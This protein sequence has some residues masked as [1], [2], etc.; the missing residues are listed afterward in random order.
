[1]KRS[2]DIQ[3][4][5]KSA[6]RVS[7][8]GAKLFH[9]ENGLPINRIAFTLARK[10]GNAVER[11]Y[12]KRLGREAY[13]FLKNELKQGNDIVLLVFPGGDSLERRMAQLRQ[14]FFKAGLIKETE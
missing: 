7:C 1:M 3:A 12:A 11:N 14:L 13:R 5:F 6:D 8:A 10:F 2:E 4:L 9:R